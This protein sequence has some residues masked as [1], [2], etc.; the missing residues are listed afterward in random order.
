MLASGILPKIL[1]GLLFARGRR[2]VT[3]WLRAA[4]IRKGY[5]EYYYF[6]SSLGRKSKEVGGALLQR[7]VKQL[8]LGD[9]LVVWHRRFAHQALR[10]QRPRSRHPPQSN[11]G[12]RPIRSLLWSRL[13]DDRLALAASALGHDC[14][15]V[16]GAALCFRQ[17]NIPLLRGLHDWQFHTKLEQAV[18]LMKWVVYRLAILEQIAV[19]RGGWGLRQA[20]FSPNR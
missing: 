19:G 7:I 16:A 6:L 1:A 15:A 9:R 5:D 2:T 13:G 10:S 18:E 4:G 11:S 20:A 3:S 14:P 17:K 12:T 8:P